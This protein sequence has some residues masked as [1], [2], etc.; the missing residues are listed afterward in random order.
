MQAGG[1]P[2]AGLVAGFAQALRGCA[3]GGCLGCVV[4]AAAK[5]GHGIGE[6]GDLRGQ[7]SELSEAAGGGAAGQCQE[8]GGGA[9]LRSASCDR[10]DTAVGSPGRAVI[11][12]GGLSQ[13][14]AAGH[15]GQ[16]A[17]RV[18]GGVCRVGGQGRVTGRV[19]A[20]VIR[21]G[22][23]LLRGVVVDQVPFRCGAPE[24]LVVRR[25]GA[26]RA[27]VPAA[28]QPGQ[29]QRLSQPPAPVPGWLAVLGR[30]VRAA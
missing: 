25:D 29:A 13:H 3:G 2:G 24:R 26:F 7:G 22:G 15:A 18:R 21:G 30:C 4:L 11:G 5:L 20:D 1:G 9:E 14:R 23:S 12:I 6:Q 8:P 19:P 17:E 28:A 16:D 27:G 10:R